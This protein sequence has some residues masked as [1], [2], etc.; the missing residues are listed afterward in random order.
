MQ[1]LKSHEGDVVVWRI[2]DRPA[3]WWR[4]LIELSPVRPEKRKK[5]N[6][7]PFLATTNLIACLNY[8]LGTIPEDAVSD[9]D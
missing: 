6:Y 5:P 1:F 7:S 9:G 8:T 3:C 4:V 2:H